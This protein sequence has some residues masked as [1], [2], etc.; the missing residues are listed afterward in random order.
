MCRTNHPL[1]SFAF[2][3]QAFFIHHLRSDS[4]LLQA[5]CLARRICIDAAETVVAHF[6][7]EGGSLNLKFEDVEGIFLFPKLLQLFSV[8]NLF[9]EVVSIE[10][11]FS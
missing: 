10:P 5:S 3:V 2:F 4:F 9:M 6:P 11:L 7:C 1:I 8:M